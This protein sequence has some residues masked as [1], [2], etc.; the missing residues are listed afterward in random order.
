MYMYVYV[1]HSSCII[2]EQTYVCHLRSTASSG[3]PREFSLLFIASSADAEEFQS[4]HCE[5]LL[6]EEVGH[7]PFQS[8]YWIDFPDEVEGGLE[9][10]QE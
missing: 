1:R 7:S 2:C 6:F 10:V 4:I 5:R 9:Y 8:S 3:R